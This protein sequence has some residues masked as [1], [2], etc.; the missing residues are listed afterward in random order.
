MWVYKFT[1]AYCINNT[2]KQTQPFLQIYAGSF[3][4]GQKGAGTPKNMMKEHIR[5]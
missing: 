5:E 4:L 1:F 3:Y 2:N